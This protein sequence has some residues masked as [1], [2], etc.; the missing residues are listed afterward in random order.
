MARP[1]ALVVVLATAFVV[2][3]GCAGRVGRR[4]PAT[5]ATETVAFEPG[6]GTIV[7]RDASSGSETT[8]ERRCSI[9]LAAGSDLDVELRWPDD[10]PERV[11][12]VRLSPQGRR[13]YRARYVDRSGDR[14][15][16]VGLLVGGQLGALLLA[17]GG[18]AVGLFAGSFIGFIVMEA[19]ATV[20]GL[21]SLIYGS[22]LA[23]LSDYATLDVG[24]G[25][26]ASLWI[27]TREESWAVGLRG[28]F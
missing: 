20:L 11:D 18:V 19:A 12:H 9:S 21:T 16:G 23:G 2:A 7:V 14:A 13:T 4:A 1:L 8:C 17:G 28:A 5:A 22:Y 6:A 25:V 26:S 27:E 15:S 3:T 24:R 10:G